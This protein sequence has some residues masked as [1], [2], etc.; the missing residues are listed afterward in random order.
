MDDLVE[1]IG[2][3][4]VILPI[5]RVLGASALSLNRLHACCASRAPNTRSALKGC[6]EW[7]LYGYPRFSREQT[8]LRQCLVSPECWL[9]DE[10]SGSTMLIV[11]RCEAAV[12]L[13]LHIIT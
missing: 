12:T 2:T 9:F 7:T 5:L 6:G 11:G 3:P 1:I 10:G 8:V 4:V 13:V